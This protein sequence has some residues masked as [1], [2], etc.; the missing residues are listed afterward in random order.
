MTE[1]PCVQRALDMAPPEI[2]LPLSHRCRR[3]PP[4]RFSKCQLLCFLLERPMKTTQ[5]SIT[6]A[7]PPPCVPGSSPWLQAAYL[8]T[9][10]SEVLDEILHLGDVLCVGHLGCFQ[11]DLLQT[12][13]LPR[14]LTHQGIGEPQGRRRFDFPFDNKLFD[15][16]D[17]ES[18][19]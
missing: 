18:G 4:R 17:Q 15:C 7:F 2:S 1:Q 9:G 8:H 3:K 10:S 6:P 12:T 11:L 16:C 14:F 13:L 19:T 5:C